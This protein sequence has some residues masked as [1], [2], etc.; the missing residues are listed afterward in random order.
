MTLIELIFFVS[1]FTLNFGIIFSFFIENNI[2]LAFSVSFVLYLIEVFFMLRVDPILLL[3]KKGLPVSAL[4]SSKK[5]IEC[6]TRKPEHAIMLMEYLQHIKSVNLKKYNRICFDSQK[7]LLTEYGFEKLIHCFLLQNPC[8]KGDVYNTEVEEGKYSLLTT[9]CQLNLLFDF[10]NYD[11]NKKERLLVELLDLVEKHKSEFFLIFDKPYNK[12]NSYQVSYCI[13]T[14]IL[15]KILVSSLDTNSLVVAKKKNLLGLLANRYFCNRSDFEEESEHFTP[16]ALKRLIL[17]R[18]KNEGH[19]AYSTIKIVSE[20]SR[21]VQWK[22]VK[23]Q[24]NK[25]SV[26]CSSFFYYLSMY[27]KCPSGW[28]CEVEPN[29]LFPGERYILN[30]NFVFELTNE[31]DYKYVDLLSRSFTE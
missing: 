7:K 17:S 13:T 27:G 4:I 25:K 5:F 3:V 26:S 20:K 18:F 16:L 1:A 29:D 22:V 11:K 15:I 31:G 21:E 19:Y 23:P 9:I 6:L 30:D 14:V 8:E 28:T 12:K 24:T 10:Y 2:Y